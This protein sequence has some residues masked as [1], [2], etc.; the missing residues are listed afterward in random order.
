[1]IYAFGFAFKTGCDSRE[2]ERH[3]AGREK[4]RRRGVASDLP[5]H[6]A[7]GRERAPPALPPSR[8]AYAR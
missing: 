4:E 8:V 5:S 2:E 6:A 1:V 7:Q 3:D